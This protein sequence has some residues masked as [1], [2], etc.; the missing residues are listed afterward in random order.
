MGKQYIKYRYIFDFLNQ[1][2]DRKH[3]V[4]IIFIKIFKK[5]QVKTIKDHLDID[6]S[7]LDKVSRKLKNMPVFS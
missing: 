4:I 5:L 1:I 7:M 2:F 6:K 3:E